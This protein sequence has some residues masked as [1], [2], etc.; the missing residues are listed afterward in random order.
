MRPVI[1][2]A[3][4]NP[5]L[6]PNEVKDNLRIGHDDDHDLLQN[7]VLAVTSFL[8]GP[9]G[10]LRNCL[11]DQ[12]WSIRGPNW[13]RMRLGLGNVQSIDLVKYWPFDGGAEVTLDPADYRIDYDAHGA[14][15][16]LAD[17]VRPALALRADAVTAHFKAGFGPSAD[18]VPQAVRQAMHLLVGHYYKHSEAVITGTRPTELPMGVRALL[19][20]YRLQRV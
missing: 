17:G 14:F 19:A 8:D 20:P 6:T 16:V 4:A 13:S 3:P 12:V 10:I 11:I 5:V 2:T 7:L 18:D 15:L 1:V 9:F